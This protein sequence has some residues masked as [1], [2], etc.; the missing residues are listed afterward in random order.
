MTQRPLII[1]AG[2]GGLCAALDLAIHGHRPIVLER[3]GDIGGKMVPLDV[4]DTKIDGGPTVLT[5]VWV[6]KELFEAAGTR[7]EDHVTV[8]KAS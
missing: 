8:T 5:M 7:L 2:I 3:Q 6:F 4:G 1:G